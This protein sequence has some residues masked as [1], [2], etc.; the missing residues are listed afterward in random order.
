M[1]TIHTKKTCRFMVFFLAVILFAGTLLPAGA[2]AEVSAHVPAGASVL[3]PASRL[4]HLSAEASAHVPASALAHLLA[5]ASTDFPDDDTDDWWDD[6]GDEEPG[7]DLSGTSDDMLTEVFMDA[8]VAVH[9]EAK[10]FTEPQ[11]ER[12]ERAAKEYGEKAKVHFYVLTKVIYAEN[13]PYEFSDGIE[14][15][16]EEL[17]EV[18]YASVA[19]PAEC[20]DAVIFTIVIERSL[21][22]YGSVDSYTDR[23]ADVS[24]QGYGKKRLDNNRAQAVFDE[25]KSTLSG[26]N[27]AGA[28][29]DVME[30]SYEYMKY[31]PGVDPRF[32]LF[33]LWFQV[34]LALGAGAVIVGIMVHHAGGKI[35]VN[36]LTYLDTAN[37][38]IL[39]RRDTYL[40]T[41]V[42]KTRKESSSG[43]GGG[44]GGHSG[45]SG[46]H[47]G[48]H[49]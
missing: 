41:S 31:R 2:K 7:G 8:S 35:T 28:A 11:I 12:L 20:E 32:V 39:A 47:G 13:P 22:D 14:W 40:R 27:Y 44:G 19:K 43:G 3:T 42:T 23:Y 1:R 33:R 37:S 48:G 10:L 24:G 21:D 25:V 17:S 29:E 18:F 45:G 26:S 46:S 30:I 6:D 4:P 16:T 15:Y 38:R 5:Q 49:F 9:D 36:N 34:I